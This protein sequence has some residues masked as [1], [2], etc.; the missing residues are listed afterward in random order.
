MALSGDIGKAGFTA[1][2]ISAKATVT[3]EFVDG[4]PTVVSSALVVAAK[5]PGLDAAKFAELAE[6]TRGGCPISR[7]LNAKLSVEARLEG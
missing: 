6:G 4:K 5:V 2:K 3:L 1:E 7:L